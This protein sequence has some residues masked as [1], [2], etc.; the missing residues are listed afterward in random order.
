MGFLKQD[1]GGN[2][3]VNERGDQRIVNCVQE[4]FSR[5]CSGENHY[6]GSMGFD[7]FHLIRYLFM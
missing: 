7:T 2:G 3:G 1:L 4:C 5:S 6:G